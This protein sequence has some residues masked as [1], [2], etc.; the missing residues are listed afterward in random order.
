MASA[1]VSSLVVAI[2]VTLSACTCSNDLVTPR[3]ADPTTRSQVR[4][5]VA[6]PNVGS[7]IIEQNDRQLGPLL[8]P[9]DD[10]VTYQELPSGVRNIRLKSAQGGR[11][12]YSANLGLHANQRHTLV[13][14]D[15]SERMRGVLLDDVAPTPE[16]GLAALRIVNGTTVGTC[17]VVVNGIQQTQ[18]TDIVPG[19]ATP[20]VAIRSGTTVTVVL[21]HSSQPV[22]FT[23]P[24]SV[25]QEFSACTIVVREVANE[26]SVLV[27]MN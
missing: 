10:V 12:V 5:V 8:D 18:M 21:Q 14:L 6:S 22:T 20:F 26:P 16:A 13:V 25:S 2:A 1:I 4:I 3:E 11:V 19:Q 9:E 7:L 17:D 27:L 24:A 15:R 23:M